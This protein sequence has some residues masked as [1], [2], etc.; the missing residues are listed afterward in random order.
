MM[1]EDRLLKTDTKR[2]SM[3]PKPR[4]TPEDLI[5]M[6]RNTGSGNGSRSRLLDRTGSLS[7]NRGGDMISSWL[8]RGFSWNEMETDRLEKLMIPSARFTHL[9]M[10]GLID[11][12]I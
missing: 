10:I 12:V 11:A 3:S 9:E 7:D 2:S 4:N 5:E 8:A 1:G 6:D